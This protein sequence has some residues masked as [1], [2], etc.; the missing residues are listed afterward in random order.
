MRSSE[1]V[2]KRDA[3]QVA[4]RYLGLRDRTERELRAHLQK[5]EFSLQSIE[6]AIERLRGW[7]YLDDGRLALRWGKERM[8]RAQWGPDRVA[9]ELGR[10]GVADQVIEDVLRRLMDDRDEASLARAAAERY[11]RSHPGMAGT[12]G[13]RRLAGY[14]G[15][16]GFSGEVIG[17][18]VREH[19]EEVGSPEN[20]EV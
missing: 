11:L 5:K 10:R 12:Q 13:M 2:E 3:T 19:T 20:S 6:G 18:T 8:E 15:R 14:L 4:L 9:R 1:A 7:G 16:R 17:R